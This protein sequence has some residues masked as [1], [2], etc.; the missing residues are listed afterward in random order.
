[1]RI[2]NNLTMILKVHRQRI[3]DRIYE[4]RHGDDYL[5]AELALEAHQSLNISE[6]ESIRAEVLEQTEY[7]DFGEVM[8]HVYLITAATGLT[9]RNAE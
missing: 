4:F 1:M 6:W 9:P 3:D 7:D 8:T 5:M 2:V